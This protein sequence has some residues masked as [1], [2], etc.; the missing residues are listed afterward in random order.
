MA[1]LTND[2]MMPTVTQKLA[3]DGTT[4]SQHRSMSLFKMVDEDGSGQI[5]KSEFGKLYD[6]IK[7]EVNQEYAKERD[8][9]RKALRSSRQVKV[10]SLVAVFLF[11][12]VA[13]SVAA[14]A[15]LTFL[16][17]DKAKTTST[18]ADGALKVKG[19]EKNVKVDTATHQSAFTA[20]M[21]VNSFLDD[22]EVAS[23]T[24]AVTMGVGYEGH[25]IHAMITHLERRVGVSGVPL[26][27]V[28]GSSAQVQP[29]GQGA[30]HNMRFEM[31]LVGLQHTIYPALLLS[32]VVSVNHTTG[33]LQKLGP[34]F[35]SFGAFLVNSTEIEDYQDL[36][37]S[38]D[39]ELEG[40]LWEEYIPFSPAHLATR[41]RMLKSGP[42]LGDLKDAADAIKGLWEHYTS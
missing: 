31:G 38:D 3:A 35:E 4:V 23:N 9:E 41:G 37:W 21:M 24:K 12:V 20:R 1:P 11:A 10:V 16:V 26:K 6:A 7:A 33:T 22:P 27:I 19:S 15:A 42:T 13:V 14:N 32:R 34:E 17:V 40:F 29:A 25:D 2:D 39:D 18:S 5:D 36:M 8:L 28:P 30:A